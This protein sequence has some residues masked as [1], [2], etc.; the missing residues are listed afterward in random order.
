MSLRFGA[1]GP[2]DISSY[3]T[4]AALYGTA[5]PQTSGFFHLTDDNYVAVN[6]S[7]AAHLHGLD[8]FSLAFDLQRDSATTDTGRIISIYQSWGVSLGSD[9]R[10]VFSVTNSAGKDF[11]LV[12]NQAIAD[13][14]WHRVE[15]EFNSY[16]EQATLRIDGV[17]SGSMPVQGH[18]PS[19]SSWG[20]VVG[21][22]WGSSFN[23]KIRDI[24]MFAGESVSAGSGQPP[25]AAPPAPV[26]DPTPDAGPAPVT[27]PAPVPPADSEL[28][29]IAK[30]IGTSSYADLAADMSK[31]LVTDGI[32]NSGD[33]VVLSGTAGQASSRGG[34]DVLIGT[35]AANALTGGSGRDIMFGGGGGDDFQFRG[36]HI[37]GSHQDVLMDLDFSEGDRLIF[38]VYENGAFSAAA[39][40]PGL[41]VFHNGSAAIV[42]SAEGLE[43]L[44]ALSDAVTLEAHPESNSITLG[45]TQGG[46]VHDIDMFAGESVSAGS[47]QPPEAAPPAPVPP[48]DSE[49]ALIAKAIGT[50]SYA[51]LAADMSKTLVTDG[52]GDS[53][54]DVVLSG[55]A[56]QASSRGGDDV[57]IG[58]SAANA[59]TGG[60]GRDIMFGGGGGDDFQFR[61]SHITGSHQDVLMDLDFSEGDRL[62]F[63]VYENGAFSA[64]AKGPGL[65]VFHNGSA[66]IVTSAEGLERLAALSDAVTLEAHPESDSITLGITQGGVVHDIDM[67]SL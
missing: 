62:I 46:V 30:A 38:S 25:E 35:S 44:A 31:T 4:P 63:S 51:D 66:A 22:V 40:G 16:A 50:S 53:G 56:G 42:T 45:I 36:S 20:L 41:N 10:L 48:A 59:L 12:A 17:P 26:I 29:L 9:G 49:L 34:D 24:D 5:V 43:R 39:K 33:D 23:G 32:G 52:I 64:A 7:Q 47:G 1:G 18:T 55:T 67:F 15:I 65:N 2:D 60:S 21:N 13:T 3:D 8:K 19:M 14:S 54:D 57:L 28:A 6:H 27:G 58:T 37:T 11:V 61:G